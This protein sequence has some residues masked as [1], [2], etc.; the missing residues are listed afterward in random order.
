MAEFL[1]TTCLEFEDRFE[2]QI[3]HVGDKASCHEVPSL[4]HG[5]GYSGTETLLSSRILVIPNDDKLEPGHLW[6]HKKTE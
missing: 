4:L 5:I 3:L 1:T 6:R 2:G